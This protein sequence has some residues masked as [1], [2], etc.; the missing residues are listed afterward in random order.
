MNKVELDA[1]DLRLL[2]ALQADG[3]L[4][5]GELSEKVGLSQSQC[6]RRRTSL[7]KSGIISGYAAILDGPR[8]GLTITAFVEVTL[9]SH[10]DSRAKRFN[11]MIDQMDE[12]QEAYALTG[13]TDYVL[14][15]TVQ[16]LE[17]LA[18]T[19]NRKLLAHDSVARIRSSIVLER[20]KAT[21]TLPLR[22]N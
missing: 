6:S 8:V 17:A 19:L 7:E 21:T 12:V 1:L 3:R 20:L 10:S 4:T 13:D 9:H 2:S 11:T 18:E 14:K 15:L 22:A 16:D 5:N